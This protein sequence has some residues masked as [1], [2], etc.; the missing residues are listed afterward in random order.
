[1]GEKREKPK[2][3]ATGGLGLLPPPPSKSNAPSNSNSQNLLNL[4][5]PVQQNGNYHWKLKTR[6]FV[7]S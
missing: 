3:A 2:V 4:A 7:N 5:A 6:T 1:M